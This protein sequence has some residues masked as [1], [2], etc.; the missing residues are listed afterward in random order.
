MPYLGRQVRILVESGKG[1]RVQ[2][3]F[4][5]W[6][7]RITVPEALVGDERRAAIEAAVVRWYRM[8]A[9]EHLAE[10]AEHWAKLA[11]WAP[12]KV[13]VRDQRQR[14]G[15]CSPDGVLRFNW[16]IVMAT[17]ALM[18]YVVVH[19]LVHLRVKAHSPVFWAEV[20]RLM[21]DFGLRR[22]RLK[23]MGPNLTV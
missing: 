11:G 4:R 19:E 2:V 5:H 7:F 1:R 20:A 3:V 13:L 12:S 18:D 21:P 10:R 23:E 16:R 6:E 8:R 15:S 22:A 9:A 14:W 17:P